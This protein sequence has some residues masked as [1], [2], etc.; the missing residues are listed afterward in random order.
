M[1]LRVS[2]DQL[3]E[4]IGAKQDDKEDNFNFILPRR[5][6]FFDKPSITR[7][8]SR[9][10]LVVSANLHATPRNICIMSGNN[11][12]L[13]IVLWGRTAPTH[14]ISSLLVMDNF[15]TIITGCHDGQI[16][17]W[18][19]T[20]ELEICPRAMLFGHTASITC[21]AK[22]SAC[23]DK[24]YIVSASENGEMCLW[25]VNDG[26]CIEFTK[27]ACAHTGIQ[28]YQFTIGTEKEGRLLCNGH[29]PEILVVDATSLEVLY[30]LVSKI[31]PDWIS[32]MSIIRSHRTQEDTV[33]AVSVTG[34]LKVWIITAEVS[35]I[36]DLDPVFEEES[37]PIYCQGC[38]SISFCTFTQ[39]S[40]LVVCSKYWR[41]FDAVDYSL[42]CSVSSE[43]DQ[44]WTGGE[45]IAA[46]RVIIWTEEGCSYI[47]KL[48]ASCLPASEHY[49]SDVG[50]TKE[51]SIPPLV[52]SIADRLDKQEGEGGEDGEEEE[53]EEVVVEVM[54]LP[55]S[56]CDLKLYTPEL[57][58]H[59]RPLEAP[60]SPRKCTLNTKGRKKKLHVVG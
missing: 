11:L 14:C 47:Y 13:P 27:L 30:S 20:P 51:G 40:L 45:F 16:C 55:A 28:F 25:D 56:G 42:L 38:Q 36:Q 35:K 26:R 31:S 53:E 22:A 17:I 23:S 2:G 8:C 21:L 15:S 32:S 4:Q 58:Y 50:K 10:N 5:E 43:N 34:I 57:L 24:Q 18:D 3:T 6:T 52:Y 1:W 59:H 12:V 46:D 60:V 41:V 7:T 9:S 48:P 37:K 33:V 54:C 44:A 49:R 39:S 29:Y 19:M